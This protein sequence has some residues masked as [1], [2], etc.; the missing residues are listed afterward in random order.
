MYPP[1]GG[2]WGFAGW[3]RERR[4]AWETGWR[5]SAWYARPRDTRWYPRGPAPRSPR[6]GS[7]RC[8]PGGRPGLFRAE[9]PIRGPLESLAPAWPPPRPGCITVGSIGERQA[10][11][12]T[13]LAA[14]DVLR[15]KTHAHDA[16]ENA[17]QRGEPL[18]QA[19]RQRRRTARHTG[20]HT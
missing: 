8:S 15:A 9:E 4:P 1:R 16:R 7:R 2:A 17:A 3:S 10:A 20:Q 19:D 12:V 13:F 5:A 18:Q 6:P 11:G 14:A